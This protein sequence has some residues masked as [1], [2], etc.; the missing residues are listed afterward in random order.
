MNIA[1]K[2]S[3]ACKSLWLQIS[4][5]YI[6]SIYNC[7]KLGWLHGRQI[8]FTTCHHFPQSCDCDMWWFLLVS[9]KKCLFKWMGSLNDCCINNHH[10]KGQKKLPLITWVTRLMNV[11]IY[12]WI[13]DLNYSCKLRTTCISHMIN[14]CKIMQ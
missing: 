8:I 5:T 4:P 7:F 9:S 3:V 13:S 11:I 2:L 10:K 14:I 12:T 6:Q 1:F